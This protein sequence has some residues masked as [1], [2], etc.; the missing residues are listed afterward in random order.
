MTHIKISCSAFQLDCD[1][2]K[3][4]QVNRSKD[5][6]HL[7]DM[8]PGLKKASLLVDADR[9]LDGVLHEADLVPPHVVLDVDPHELALDLRQGHV[10][11][12]RDPANHITTLNRFRSFF[13]TIQIISS[14]STFSTSHMYIK[15]GHLPFIWVVVLYVQ[16]GANVGIYEPGELQHFY[17]LE[18]H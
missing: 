8:E 6:S 9:R 13:D 15:G 10:Q 1:R 5:L 4:E 14:H 3:Y 2:P 7:V 17:S 11:P 16:L 18:D 12:H